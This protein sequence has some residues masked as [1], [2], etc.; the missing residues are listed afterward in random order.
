MRRAIIPL[1]IAG[2]AVVCFLPALSGEFLNWDDN[3]NFLDNPAYRGVGW[4]QIR[5]ALTSVLFGHYIPLT[6]LSWNLNFAL[7]GMDPFGYHLANLL[8]HAVNAVLCYYVARRLLA[9]VVSVGSQKARRQPDI[10]AGAAVTAIVFAIHPL[11]VEPVSWIT[12]RADLLCGLFALL[13]VWAYLWSVET[14]GPAR[15]WPVLATALALAAALLSK[16]VALSLPAA[17]FL[18]DIYPLRRLGQVRTWTMVREKTPILLVGLGGAMLVLQ[19]LRHGAV[20]TPSSTYGLVARACVAGYSFTQSLVRFIWPVSLS[21]LYEMPAPISPLDARFGLAMAAAVLITAALIV[22]R[23]RWP[24]GL[25]AWTYSL[26]VLAP[27]SLALRRGVDLAPDRYSYLAGLGFEVLVGGLVIKAIRLIQHGTVSRSL[28]HIAGL[29]GLA[30]LAGLGTAS[31][32][33]THMWTDSETLWQW[34][35]DLD[36]TCSICQGK[37]GESILGGHDGT[38]RVREAEALFRRAIALRPDLPDAYFNLG[39][40]LVLQRRYPEAEEPLRVYIERAPQAAA[41]PER[42]GLLYLLE[43][44]HEEAIPLLRSAFGRKPDA[45]LLRGYLVQALDARARE[46]VTQ[47]LG[48]Q[49]DMLRNE[50]QTLGGARA[51]EQVRP[52]AVVPGLEPAARP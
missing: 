10:Q 17:L 49:A 4:P 50:A 38:A 19:A 34:A 23:K 27:T 36:P 52:D 35:V 29:A 28:G 45:S 11:R 51:A 33:L 8:L 12:A 6:R 44:R 26:L 1:G 31:W 15:P 32:S 2:L 18:L 3:V 14:D 25:A 20:L 5:W 22:V 21:P 48:D 7:G 9:A 16:G 47:G 43:G 24:G 30:A 46:L 40:A 41:G 39:T 13:A 42:L 37:L